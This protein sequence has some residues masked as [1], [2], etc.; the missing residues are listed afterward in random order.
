LEEVFLSKL[1]TR[2]GNLVHIC[3]NLPEDRRDQALEILPSLESAPPRWSGHSWGRCFF[4]AGHPTSRWDGVR[5]ALE[6]QRGMGAHA[7][8]K[9]MAMA[10]Q[11]GGVNG[12]TAME[13]AV[14]PSL[15]LQE[16]LGVCWHKQGHQHPQPLAAAGGSQAYCLCP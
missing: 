7:G 1:D 8:E 10:L 9:C 12:K 11:G 4:R 13:E 6:Q 15:W 2:A 14:A 3:A 5:G 16:L